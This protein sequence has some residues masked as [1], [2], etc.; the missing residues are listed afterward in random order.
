MSP[1]FF[2][3]PVLA[4]AISD[5]ILE[6]NR[7]GESNFGIH[8]ETA[9][10]RQFGGSFGRSF[11]QLDVGNFDGIGFWA[12][13]APAGNDNLRISVS[14]RH[15]DQNAPV[16]PG[17]DPPCLFDAPQDNLIE[18]AC[19]KFGRFVTLT[20]D[21][22]Y[23]TVPFDEMRQSGFGKAAPFLD[24][25]ALTGMSFDFGTGEWDFWLDDVS[26]YRR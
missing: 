1:D 25:Q 8:I 16:D 20:N 21:W 10:L 14:E 23:Y 15:T 22:E 17:E 9:P 2:I 5:P 11:P 18:F 7:C 4:N 13:K 12:R 19:D 26:F 6:G 3:R 24:Q